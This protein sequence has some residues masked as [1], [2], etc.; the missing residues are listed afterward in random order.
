MSDVSLINH[1]E[2]DSIQMEVLHKFEEFQ[3]A[4]I[5][6]DAKMLNS[7]MDED[8]TLIHMSGKIQTKQEYIED[9][10]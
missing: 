10:V 5:D 6:K 2:F 7:I 9:I 3:Q 4:M 1:S 8:Y